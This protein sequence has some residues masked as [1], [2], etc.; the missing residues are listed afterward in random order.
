MASP[1]SA[2]AR[3]L[4]LLLFSRFPLALA[5]S[6]LRFFMAAL[7]LDWPTMEGRSLHGT[8]Q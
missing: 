7:L 2:S 1:A 3:A 6:A 8:Q 4:C 5:A